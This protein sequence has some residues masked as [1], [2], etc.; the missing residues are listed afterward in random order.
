MERRRRL[1]RRGS[2]RAIGVPARVLDAES[3]L[4]RS[5][6]PLCHLVDLDARPVP[7]IAPAS[8]RPRWLA[9]ADFAHGDHAMMRCADCHADAAASEETADLLLPSL[10]ACGGCHG[11][12][13]PPPGVAVVRGPDACLDCHTYHPPGLRRASG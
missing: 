6:C 4:F 8:I 1:P 13:Q 7:A 10:A 12:G 11:G 9:H 3:T 5:A 2:A